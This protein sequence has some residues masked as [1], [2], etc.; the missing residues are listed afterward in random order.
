MREKWEIITID[1]VCEEIVD[2]LNRTAPKVDYITPFKMIRTSNVRHGRIDLDDVFFVNEETYTKWTRRLV[3]KKGDIILTREAPLG[4]VGI[5]KTDEKV[6]LGQRTVLY[7]ANKDVCDPNF[8]YYSLLA[9]YCQS[10]IKAYGSGSTVEHMKVPDS[11]K[12]KL[13]LPPLPTQRKIAGILSAYD[14]LI[15][16]NLKRIKLLEEKARLT[17]EE[18]FVRMKFPG[19]EDVALDKETG[20]PEGWE[21]VKLGDV[22]NLIK[23]TVYP[24]DLKS[25]LP[26]IGLEHIPRKSI[27][28]NKWETSEKVDSMKFRYLTGDV[29]FGKIRPYFHKVGVALNIGI[30]STDTIVLRPT[31]KNLHGIILQTVFSD[32]FVESAT[33]SSNGTKMPRANWNVLQNYIITLP[34]KSLQD[35]FQSIS[36]AIVSQLENLSLQNQHLKEACDLL[37]PRLMTGMVDVE[38]LVG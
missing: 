30:T 9:P 25:P 19:H 21:R 11:K 5:L 7:R 35:S 23:D 3:P 22:V 13:K 36:S 38:D 6:F 10:N 14:D 8:L 34:C 16:N 4:E 37:L 32:E 1:S 27:T 12:I 15:E 31:V 33:Q 26:Y 29:L 2:C 28:L 24:S 18:W 17:Y 20:L